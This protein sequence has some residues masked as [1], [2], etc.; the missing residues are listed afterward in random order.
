M[1]IVIPGG[2]GQVGTL[3]ARALHADGHVV[4]V[5]SRR[6]AANP[7]R[8]VEW[9]GRTG[10]AWIRELDGADVLI[11]LAGQSVNCRYHE[12]N[13]RAIMSSRIESTRAI[14]EALQHVARP[15]QVWLQAS[16]ATIYAHRYDAPNDELTG[17]LGGHEPDAPSSWN[18]SIDVAT[19][20]EREAIEH[21]SPRTRQ[22]LLRSAMTMSAD[23]GGVFDYLLRLVRLGLGGACGRGDQFMSWI[24][25]YDFIRAIYWLIEHDELA[26]GVNL[27]APCPLPNREFMQALRGAWGITRGLPAPTWLLE[28]GTFVLRTESELVLKSRRV[29]PTR[30][31]QS[32]F[33]FAY[34]AWSDAAV[35]LCDRWRTRQRLA[36]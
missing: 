2:S 10:G 21:Q 28:F 12:R 22:V 3:L 34:R 4:V 7:W 17:I 24:H 31:L 15:P 16:T 27:A 25:E 5:L 32:G 29:V 30:L 9:D 35:E 1:K 8:T 18:F 13:R 23:S 14:G 33:E 6:K 19:A 11:N 26:G 20:W 36:G